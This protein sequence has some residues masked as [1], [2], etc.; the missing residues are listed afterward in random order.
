M[1]TFVFTTDED[2]TIEQA[3]EAIQRGY[4]LNCKITVTQHTSPLTDEEIRD[5]AIEMYPTEEY[6]D[7]PQIAAQLHYRAGYNACLSDL[8]LK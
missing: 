8:G 1:K 7:L 2:L 4:G 5:R 3:T 6:D